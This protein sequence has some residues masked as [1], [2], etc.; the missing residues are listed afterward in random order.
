MSTLFRTEPIRRLEG[1]IA[2]PRLP[3]VRWLASGLIAVT[4]GLLVTAATFDYPRTETV[5]GVLAPA[6]GLGR[7]LAPQGGRVI[8]VAVEAGQ[9]VRDGQPIAV[10]RLAP[11]LVEG[12]SA[13][14]LRAGVQRETLAARTTAQTDLAALA[15]E[16]QALG[17][18][19]RSLRQQIAE[20]HTQVDIQAQQV[21]LAQD[22]LKR[23]ESL[24]S[25][26]LL[27]RRD[28]DN[29]RT[30]ALNAL[31]RLSQIRSSLNQQERELSDVVARIAALPVEM[32]SARAQNESRDAQLA[33]KAIETSARDGYVVT[34]PLAG[35]VASLSAEPGA[36]LQ[37]G[38]TLAIVTPDKAR[39][40]AELLAT[41]AAIGFLQ[42][43]QSVRLKY[44]AYPYQKF[45]MGAGR[46]VAIDRAALHP[47]EI[48]AHGVSEPVYRVTV[49]LDADTIGAYGRSMPLMADMALTA[50]IVVDRRNLLDWLFDPIRAARD[51]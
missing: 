46:I 51:V 15:L 40:Q 4:F 12:D 30:V 26:G 27:T 39:L 8:S 22:E 6:G 36:T 13:V 5:S 48:D 20:T 44:H 11:D 9:D 28:M 16:R 18:K 23:S 35:R 19:Q 2:L 31:M 34:A 37:S 29:R 17:R 21:A 10:L 45:G 3:R 49:S 7:V 25:Q 50:E 1:R 32:A 47:E 42:V 33:Q 38:Q 24:A 14:A 41:S 43:G